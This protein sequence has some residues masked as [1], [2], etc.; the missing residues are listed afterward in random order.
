[1]HYFELVG[2][3]GI[4]KDGW[5]VGG[6]HLLPWR[7]DAWEKADIGQHPWAL[8]N[9]NEDH[10]QA[11]DL[12][13][14]D[15]EKLKELVA[16]LDSEAPRNQVDPLAPHAGPQPVISAERSPVV[17]RFGGERLP[18]RQAPNLRGRS[19]AITADVEIPAGGAEGVIV[20]EGGA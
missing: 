16:Q 12:A 5:R 1:M 20:A 18:V 17:L 19:H 10:S 6:R 15:P 2:N 13:A 7:R 9:L 14:K 11:H 4:C 3:R 8:C